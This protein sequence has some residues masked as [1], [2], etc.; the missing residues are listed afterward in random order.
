MKAF[1]MALNMLCFL[2]TESQQ[3]HVKMSLIT[4][5]SKR[6]ISALVIKDLKGDSINIYVCI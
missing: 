4:E 2:N 1:T 3:I 6:K 5:I